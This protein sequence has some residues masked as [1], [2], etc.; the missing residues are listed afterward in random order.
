LL[1]DLSGLFAQ[2]FRDDEDDERTTNA[3]AEEHVDE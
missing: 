1:N 3:S 2:Q